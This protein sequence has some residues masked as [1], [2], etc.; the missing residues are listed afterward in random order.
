MPELESIIESFMSSP[1]SI[2]KIMDVVK[3]FGGNEEKTNVREENKVSLALPEFGGFDS[4]MISRVMELIQNYNAD[5][6]RRIKLL[7]AIRPYIRAEDEIH[8]ERAI[9]IVKLSY[10]A[11]SVLKNF[12]K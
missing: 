2:G 10:V 5:G 9:Q 1:E 3:M 8:I 11:K 7:M 12:I 6:D 4:D